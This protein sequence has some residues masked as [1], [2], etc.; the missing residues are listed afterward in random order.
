[1]CSPLHRLLESLEHFHDQTSLESRVNDI[2]GFLDCDH[3][4]SLSKEEVNAGLRRLNYEPPISLGDD[5]WEMMVVR[6]HL[7]DSSGEVDKANFLILMKQQLQQYM[8][9]Q[10]V[11]SMAVA[12]PIQ[13]SILSVLKV[14]LSNSD[15]A[16][17]RSQACPRPVKSQP[18]LSSNT[19][20]GCEDGGAKYDDLCQ[21]L[22]TVVRLVEEKETN[23]ERE[24][25]KQHERVVLLAQM[26]AELLANQERM[27]ARQISVLHSVGVG[28]PVTALSEGKGEILPGG[29]GDKRMAEIGSGHVL[30]ESGD[31]GPRRLPR[32]APR[33]QGASEPLCMPSLRV[34]VCVCT[35][36]KVRSRE[37]GGGVMRR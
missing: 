6:A 16:A 3:S 21:L 17:S 12:D 15:P 7:C 26:N 24:R 20:G 32:P 9:S 31:G 33:G 2:Y 34:C 1:M 37:A 10:L 29:G 36:V 19:Q 22:K 30:D 28:L 25:E 27:L 8:L 18:L 11:S 35:R 4:G 5:D 23:W 13:K 14:V